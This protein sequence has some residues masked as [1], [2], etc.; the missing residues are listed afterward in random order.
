[1][2]FMKLMTNILPAY[3]T[4]LEKEAKRH[5]KSK[6][7]IIEEAIA[8]YMYMLYG[9]WYMVTSVPKSIRRHIR[10]EKARIRGEVFKSV[11]QREKIQ[12]LYAR[13]RLKKDNKET[14]AKG[15]KSLDKN[16]QSVTNK[17]PRKGSSVTSL[18]DKIKKVR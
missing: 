18:R 4:F 11:K 10:L 15:A 7:Q 13:F 9:G 17:N 3:Y 8:L 2:A 6:R 16:S 14:E 1:M 5:H 12:A